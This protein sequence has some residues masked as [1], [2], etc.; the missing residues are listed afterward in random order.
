MQKKLIAAAVA[1]ALGMPAVA[2]AQN[3]TVNVYGR[4]YLEY[5]VV[6]QNRASAPGTTTGLI[7]RVQAEAIGS[8]GSAIG[9][10]GEEKLGGGLSAWFQCETTADFRGLNQD[11]MCGRNSALGLKGGLGNLFVGNWQTPFTLSRVTTGSNETGVFGTAGLLTGHSTTVGD[12][13]GPQLYGRRQMNSVNYHS[14]S[15]SGFNVKLSTTSQNLATARTS[16]D[17]N[18]KPRLFS[19]SGEYANGPLQVTAA[20]E[21]HN[22]HLGAG[23]TTAASPGAAVGAIAA[24]GF[25]GD[26]SG[27]LI[28]AAYTFG[29]VKLGGM[30]TKQKWD[31]TGGAGVYAVPAGAIGES[32]V[33]AWQLG[34]EWAL[35]GPH[36]IKAAYTRASD[37]T[38]NGAAAT[39][40]LRPAAGG[41]PGA[42]E[43]AGSTGAK[44]YQVRYFHALSKRTDFSIG[45]TQ[46][47]NDTYG[48]YNI[49]G[50]G[51]NG[52][53]GGAAGV[54]AKHT[55]YAMALDHRF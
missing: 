26:E 45:M 48:G 22:N 52:G 9:F 15:F 54:G 14:P 41:A 17:A 33:N 40:G 23:Q 43:V 24:G 32:S 31:T 21:Q 28:G 10:R 16:T 36:S 55:G 19:V 53:A 2:L 35:S 3:A 8:P 6:N 11:G 51:G 34:V 44:M 13:V 29:K 30:Y 39:G 49:N 1:G 4:A 47:K 5:G 27:W 46:V 37:V 20:F 18:A 7:D 42:G 38:G 50:V 12:G 25:S